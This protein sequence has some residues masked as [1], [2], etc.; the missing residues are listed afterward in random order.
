ML[1]KIHWAYLLRQIYFG[2][3]YVECNEGSNIGVLMNN[4]NKPLGGKH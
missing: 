4:K 2:S 3:K 1:K